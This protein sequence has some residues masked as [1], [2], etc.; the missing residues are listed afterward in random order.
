MDT[1]SVTI[2]VLE[3]DDVCKIQR[4]EERNRNQ[5]DMDAAKRVYK[6]MLK[7]KEKEN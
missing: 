1:G 5:R 3:Q 4:D 6:Q 2:K 7:T